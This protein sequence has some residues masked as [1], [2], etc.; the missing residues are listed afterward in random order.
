MRPVNLNTSYTL[1]FSTLSA[2][3]AVQ[4]YYSYYIKCGK[5]L[6]PTLLPREF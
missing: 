5:V 1:G 6:I 2:A 3:G 4:F